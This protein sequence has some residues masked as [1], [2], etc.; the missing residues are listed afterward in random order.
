MVLLIFRFL[1]SQDEQKVRADQIIFV[2]SDFYKQHIG[3]IIRAR[4]R[5]NL[6]LLKV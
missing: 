1:D 6:M 3:L 2:L 4:D 5:F